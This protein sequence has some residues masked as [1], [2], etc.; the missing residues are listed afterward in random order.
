MFVNDQN[1][2]NRLTN[3]HGLGTKKIKRKF[4]GK[5]HVCLFPRGLSIDA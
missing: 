2:A 3:L 5:K 1:Q 4:Q